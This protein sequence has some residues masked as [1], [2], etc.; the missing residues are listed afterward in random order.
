MP[1]EPEYFDSIYIDLVKK[2]YYN[3]NKVQA[4]FA[5]IRRQAEELHAENDMLRA[6]LAAL[7]DKKVELGGAVLSAQMVYRQIVDTADERAAAIV[8]EAEQKSAALLAEA[9]QKSASLVA[10]AQRER[11]ALLA[12]AEAQQEHAVKSVSACFEL[13]RRQHLEAIEA[14]NAQWQAFL[15][16]L[17][18]AE[19][20][21]AAPAPAEERQPAAEAVPADL[22]EKVGAIAREFF[23]IGAD[24]E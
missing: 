21:G 20:S 2:K 7:D 13:A 11:D 6:Q 22:E 1:L 10:A 19:E 24:A 9:E 4:V 15:C 12:G 17:S 16:G 8:S 23:S 3:A 5:E 14:L 18:P